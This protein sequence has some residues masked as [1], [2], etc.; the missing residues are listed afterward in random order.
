MEKDCVSR[1]NNDDN[2]KATNVS[3]EQSSSSR[4]VARGGPGGQDPPSFEEGGSVSILTPPTF[5]I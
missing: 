4:G 1:F 5:E 3:K 2:T